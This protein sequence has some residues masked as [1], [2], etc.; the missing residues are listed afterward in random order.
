[1][2][3]AADRAFAYVVISVADLERAL[4]LWAKRF[5]MQIVA[6]RTGNDPALAEVWGLDRDAIVDQALLMTPGATEGGVH[7]VQFKFPGPAVRT[8]AAPT[9]LV[10]KSV[11]I[12]V[13]DIQ[14]RYAELEAAGYQFRSKPGRFESDGAIVFETHMAA[15]DA[16]NIVLLEEMGKTDLVSAEGYGVA[17]QIVLIT[18]D[19]LSEKVFLESVLNLVEASY[20]RFAGPEIEKTIGL[21]KGASLDIR[22]LGDP[23]SRYGRLELVQYAGAKST[24]LYPRTAPPAR[25]M[26][27]ATY[28]VPDLKPILVRA[29]TYGIV[30]HGVVSTVLGTGHMAHVKMPSGFRLD[31][32]Q[33]K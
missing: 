13:R 12:V 22:I 25:G 9:D 1:M 24:N 15:H 14:S 17:P 26:L 19:N 4:G 20:H 10:P 27:S 29:A 6:R 7:L 28:F 23:A 8:D 3:A 32:I 18:P 31:L 30:D 2:P 33:R 21:P 5:G 11:D 16:L